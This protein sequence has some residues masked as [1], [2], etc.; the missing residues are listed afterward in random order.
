MPAGLEIYDAKGRPL[1]RYDEYNKYI[2]GIV[3]LEPI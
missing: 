2:L 1:L 3:E